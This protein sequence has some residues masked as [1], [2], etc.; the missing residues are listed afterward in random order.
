VPDIVIHG[1]ACAAYLVLAWHFWNTRWRAA[2]PATK[3]ESWERGAI[4]LPLALHGAL[5]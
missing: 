1:I 3:L 4:V 5:L 2:A